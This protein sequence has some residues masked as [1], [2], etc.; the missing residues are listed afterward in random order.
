MQQSVNCLHLTSTCSGERNPRP[1][2]L[3]EASVI[4]EAADTS[5]DLPAGLKLEDP[6]VLLTQG[7]KDS[8][9]KVIRE[10]GVGMAY[11]WDAAS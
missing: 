9:I 1:D 11:S 8:Q 3:T 6:G 4:A 10:E 5:G 2:N 7:T